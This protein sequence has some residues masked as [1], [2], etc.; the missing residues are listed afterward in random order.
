[1]KQKSA[2][3]RVAV[4]DHLTWEEF[5]KIN[6]NAPALPGIHPEVGLSRHYPHGELD[7]ARGGL[8]GRVTQ[9]DLDRIT[10]R[11]ETPDPVLSTPGLSR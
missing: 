9:R 1:M 7:G 2:F 8:C 3:V 6:A 5:A 10:E 4:I 11:G